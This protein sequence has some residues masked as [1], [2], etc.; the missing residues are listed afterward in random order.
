MTWLNF[1]D[2]LRQLQSIGLL[3]DAQS[4]IVDTPKPKR[5]HVD[6]GGREK[7]GW[8][9][10]S[11]FEIRGGLYI[12][13]SYGVW[14][15]ADRGKLNIEVRLDGK[16]IDQ[17]AEERAAI[18][19]RNA[20]RQRAAAA[21][22][23]SEAERAARQARRVWEAYLPAGESAYLKRKSVQAHGL[24]FDPNGA[25]TLVVPMLRDHQIVGLQLIRG[26][27][28]GN[29]LEKEYWPAGM[30]KVGAYHQ[31]GRVVAGGVCIVAEGYATGAS[32]F[33]A[34]GQQIPVA[35]A[36]DAGSPGPVAEALAKQHRG[37]RLVI[38]ADDDRVQRC[39][40]PVAG[41]KEGEL[42][43]KYTRVDVDLCQHCGQPHQQR[44]PGIEAARLA[45][46]AVGG[47]WLK[48]EW[49]AGIEPVVG[50]PMDPPAAKARH[51]DFNDLHLVAGLHVVRQQLE[52]HLLAAGCG[53]GAGPARTPQGAGGAQQG[54][55]AHAAG[56]QEALDGLVDEDTAMQRY[57]LVYAGKGTLFDHL[58]HQL[59]AK[60]DVIDVLVKGAWNT[61]KLRGGLGV[62][63]M[64]EVG[65]DPAGTDP[66]I[67]CNLWRGWPTTPKAGKCEA[68]LALL[69]H[70]CSGEQNARDLYQWTLKWLALPLQKPG[71]KMKTALIFH[72]PQGT[73]KSQ[74]FEAIMQIYGEYGRVVDQ[75]AIEDK[76]NDWASRKL[77]LIADEVVTRAEIW[78]VKNKLKHFVTGDTIRINPKNVASYTERNHVNVVYL[79]NEKQPLPIERDDRRHLVIW[80]PEKLGKWT[81]NDVAAEIAAGG[82]AALHQHLLDVDLDGFT[83]YTEPPMSSAKQD[84]IDVSLE[85]TERFLRDWAA[86]D[87]ELTH[88]ESGPVRLPYCPCNSGDCYT[89]YKRWCV[90]EGVSRPREQAQFIGLIAKLP[91]WSRTHKDIH[92]SMHYQGATRRQRMIVQ[93]DASLTEAMKRPG[94][95][96]HRRKEGQTQAQWLTDCFFAFRNAL[97]GHD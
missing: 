2:A 18:R 70:L 55:G 49:P 75:S 7:R 22:R 11:S 16:A 43:G 24:R 60:S 68:L 10:L 56:G 39:R 95:T 67:R 72:G 97:P 63:R 71:A 21:M 31:L 54:G 3:V 26:Q 92:T 69:E 58:E 64:E 13:G 50:E 6:G 94:A 8:Y 35:V 78:H 40:A 51:T 76:F 1:D 89:A 53:A 48:P 57:S 86:G 19:K 84:L 15:G 32:I 88:N 96:D 28:R 37:V 36:F 83:E 27:K 30:D 41:A 74:F 91:G 66:L 93:G 14:Q 81:Y 80:C 17:S 52:A 82:I 23:K 44:N 33:E 85:S 9:W 87:I 73:G 46:H 79:S 47:T 25:G 77:F 20:E 61:I 4:L 62:V 42:C 45:A 38:A 12:T 5:C 29:K 59:V 65:F 90:Q 34:L